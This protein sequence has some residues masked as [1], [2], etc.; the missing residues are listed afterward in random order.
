MKLLLGVIMVSILMVSFT[1]SYAQTPQNNMAIHVQI[2]VENSDGALVSYLETSRVIVT[3]YAGLNALL[4]TNAPILHKKIISIGD[5]KYE[6]VKATAVLVHSYPTI[7]SENLISADSSNSHKLLAIAEHDGYPVVK[8][9]KV[10]TYWT[11]L[12]PAS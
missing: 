4:D 6:L 8:G 1:N 9:D 7:I 5:Q 3:D 12:R 11:I 10:T 2:K